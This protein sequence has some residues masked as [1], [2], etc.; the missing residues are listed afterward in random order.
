MEDNLSPPKP[1]D[2][3]QTPLIPPR[4]NFFFFSVLSIYISPFVPVFFVFFFFLLPD[5]PPFVDRY[6]TVTVFPVKL[7]EQ[8]GEFWC[9]FLFHPP[10][11][12]DLS[13]WAPL[14]CDS[15]HEAFHLTASLL[16]STPLLSLNSPPCFFPCSG[17]PLVEDR[18]FPPLPRLND[19]YPRGSPVEVRSYFPQYGVA[20]F[21]EPG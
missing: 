7:R 11:L 2:P 13:P 6:C 20:F 3:Y 4:R 9:F 16:L 8:V 15:F 12:R 19:L 1:T 17:S 14:V 21:H 18:H 5:F 10:P